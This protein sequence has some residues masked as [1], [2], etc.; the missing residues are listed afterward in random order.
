M[1]MLSII[2]GVLA[3]MNPV[4]ASGLATIIVAWMF[5]IFGALQ[6][7]AGFRVEGL[8]QKYGQF[9]SVRWLSISALRYLG[10]R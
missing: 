4:F 2:G 8:V 1:A 9:C 3:L 7:I 5:I 10:I 6:V